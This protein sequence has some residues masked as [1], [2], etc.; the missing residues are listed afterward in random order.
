MPAPFVLAQLFLSAPGAKNGAFFQRGVT[1]RSLFEQHYSLHTVPFNSN[2]LPLKS[3]NL[4]PKETLFMSSLSA[5][6]IILADCCVRFQEKLVQIARR[7]SRAGHRQA[8][9][10]EEH[11]DVWSWEV[12]AYAGQHTTE[13]GRSL[14][15]TRLR[16]SILQR[17]Y[18]KEQKLKGNLYNGEDVVYFFIY[19]TW[20]YFVVVLL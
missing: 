16:A 6:D 17:V 10:E 14:W 12:S 13:Q 11:V 9:R 19:S 8:G 7:G 5:W 15:K 2:F 18:I 4:K 20:K 3:V 1:K